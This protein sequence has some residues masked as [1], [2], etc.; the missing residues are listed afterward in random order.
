MT[1]QLYSIMGICT[2]DI[3]NPQIKVIAKALG[4]KNCHAAK[5]IDLFKQI[6]VWVSDSLN[7]V[8]KEISPKMDVNSTINQ[9]RYF[10][11]SSLDLT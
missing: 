7:E 8:V 10:W 6:V 9:R 4:I 1:T 5:K 11:P 3:T 2:V